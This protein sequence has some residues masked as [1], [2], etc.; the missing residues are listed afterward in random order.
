MPLVP[1]GKLRLMVAQTIGNSILNG[2]T[3]Q[4]SEELKPETAQT[5]GSQPAPAV[6]GEKEI[7]R[8]DDLQGRLDKMKNPKKDQQSN[9]SDYL[10]QVYTEKFGYIPR[11]LQP[12]KEDFAEENI[13][14]DGATKVTV[15]L[16]SR[17]WGQDRK[18]SESEV[19]EMLQVIENK[20]HFY[21]NGTKIGPSE[22][23]MELSSMDPREDEKRQS[24]MESDGLGKQVKDLYSL[25]GKAAPG[26]EGEG[27]KPGQS[28]AAQN[29]LDNQK[30][31]LTLGELIKINKNKYITEL[32]KII[33]E[34]SQ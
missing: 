14:P 22:I 23:K 6:A 7:S 10:F 29:S 5:V 24:A 33:S 16:P 9:L 17:Y 1:A 15:T 13:S 2:D 28:K 34:R 30:S 4:T 25:Y 12:L 3:P 20:F 31:A 27:K 18:I 32:Q 26:T 8:V 21:H 19:K 11:I